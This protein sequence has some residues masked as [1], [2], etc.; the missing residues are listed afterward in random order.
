MST[1]VVA[2][3][4]LL[5]ASKTGEPLPEGAV[6]DAEGRPTTDPAK[7]AVPLP[8][9]GPK[10]SGLAL[11]IECLTSL[12]L[13]NPIVAEVLEDTEAGRRHRQNAFVLAIDVARFGDPAVLRREIGRLVRVLKALPRAAGVDEILMPGERGDRVLVQRSRDGIPLPPA[14]VKELRAVAESLGVTR[15]LVP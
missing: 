12:V 13:A 8:L 5:Q 11:M 15:G 3:G 14:V 2:M 6:L 7:A 10:G 9:G 4:K 1:S